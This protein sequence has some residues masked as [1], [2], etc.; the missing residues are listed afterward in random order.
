LTQRDE[1][2]NHFNADGNS[3]GTGHRQWSLTRSAKISVIFKG[4]ATYG[5]DRARRFSSTSVTSRLFINLTLHAVHLST[6]AS[7]LVSLD[8]SPLPQRRVNFGTHTF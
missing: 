7:V 2:I 8:F 5:N 4:D 1:K 6:V 3:E